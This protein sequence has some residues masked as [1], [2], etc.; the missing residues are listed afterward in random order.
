MATFR[1]SVINE[2][3]SSTNEHDT[4]SADDAKAEALKAALQMGAD[5]VIGGKQFFAAVVKVET[6][7]RTIER[8]VVSIGASPLAIAD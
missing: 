7:D 8:F 4:D 6:A 2:D 1:I 5:E 3:F